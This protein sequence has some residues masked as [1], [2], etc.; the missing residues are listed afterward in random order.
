MSKE[1][2]DKESMIFLTPKP[3]QIFFVYRI[4]SKEKAFT[5]KELFKEKRGVADGQKN[6]KNGFLTA[7]AM[8]HTTSIRKNANEL[9]VHEKTERTA[10]KQDLSHDL[11]PPNMLS[12]SF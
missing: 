12:G 3:S 5:G 9:K 8:K 6:E 2:N 10:I 4:Q 7:F 1:R 11:N